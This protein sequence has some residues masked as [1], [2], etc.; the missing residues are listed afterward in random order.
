M[1]LIFNP[2]VNSEEVPRV[3]LVKF[4]LFIFT[5]V[6]LRSF[7][8]SSY[9]KDGV[10]AERNGNLPYLF[11]LSKTTILV[12]DFAVEDLT[13]AELKSWFLPMQ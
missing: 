10:C 8:I 3:Q 1:K 4:T 5:P 11:I 6:P 12:P 9:A 7:K 13:W 2:V